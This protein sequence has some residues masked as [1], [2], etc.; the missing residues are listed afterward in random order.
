MR[1]TLAAEY[2]LGT[3]RGA[4]RL[5]FAAQLRTDPG[6]SEEVAFWEM[7]L[8]FFAGLQ[9]VAPPSEIWDRIEHV[10]RMKSGVSPCHVARFRHEKSIKA[11]DSGDG[12]CRLGWTS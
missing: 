4:A 9:A 12:R 6:L 7:H 8:A 10:T 2:V 5:R 3:L 11:V 1:R